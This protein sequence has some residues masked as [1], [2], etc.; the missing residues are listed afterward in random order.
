MR[1]SDLVL[2]LG[3]D[4]LG[5][6]AAALVA[7]NILKRDFADD[8]DFVDTIE[9]GL[10]LL[11]IFS[12]YRRVLLLDTIATGRYPPGTVLEFSREDFNMVLGP[13][14]HFMGLPDVLELADRLSID[15]PEEIRIHAL[16]IEQPSDFSQTLSP[17]IQE[18]MDAYV[19]GASEI[20]IAWKSSHATHSAPGHR[21]R[22]DQT[23]KAV[24]KKDV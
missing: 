6:D 17:V 23:S 7:A 9:T 24:K 8:A 5:D 4:I 15:V 10:A 1:S 11:D 12:G 22:L 19:R 14:P 2:A 20:L 18:A 13:S 16:E 21:E 3:N